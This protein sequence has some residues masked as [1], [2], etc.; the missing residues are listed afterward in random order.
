[1][2][3][4]PKCKNEYREGIQEC[5]DCH[6]L[7]VETLEKEVENVVE[8][9]AEELEQARMNM[10]FESVPLYEKSD[11]KAENFKSSAYTLLLV[12]IIGAV[13]LLLCA[14]HII[15]IAFSGMV[16][17][18][19]GFLFVVFIIM[20]IL[21]FGS[22]TKTAKEAVNE[23]RLLEELKEWCNLHITKPVVEEGLFIEEDTMPEEMRYYKR[24][25]KM[26]GMITETYRDLEEGFLDM[27]VEELYTELY[28]EGRIE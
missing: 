4:C 22:Y 9:R 27:I 28:G 10:P 5:A 25:D 21:S 6:V 2:S 3:W 8:E 1:M 15:P 16:Y 26:K 23:N 19:M 11:D 24:V 7:L 18:V 13:F 12:G 17:G 14:L 20:G